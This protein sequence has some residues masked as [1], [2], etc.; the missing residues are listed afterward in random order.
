MN[1]RK[2]RAK[3]CIS[4]MTVLTAP[5]NHRT[6][7]ALAEIA[8]VEKH[9]GNIP[10]HEMSAELGRSISGIQSMVHKLRLGKPGA[11]QWTEKEI[12]I[13]KTHYNYG[14]GMEEVQALLPGRSEK[15]I[16]V[17]ANRRGLVPEQSVWTPR[18][19]R[20]LKQHYGSMLARDIAKALG[21]SVDAVRTRADVCQVAK[22]TRRWT[23]NELAIIRTHYSRGIKYVLTL[24]PERTPATIQRQASKMGLRNRPH[25]TD[26]EKQIMREFYPVL[27]TTISRMLPGRTAEGIIKCAKKLGLEYQRTR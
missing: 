22:T 8:F 21:R 4:P 23:E 6:H 1:K 15:A 7:W 20:Y 17:Q 18:E 10:L 27:G 25:W 11:E 9:Y 5:R 26:E 3:G 19:L 24:L 13:L 14:E 16:R 2:D 12:E